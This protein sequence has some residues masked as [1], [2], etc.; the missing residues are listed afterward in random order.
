MKTINGICNE[1]KIKCLF[2][3]QPNI[4]TVDEQSLSEKEKQILKYDFWGKPYKKLTEIVLQDAYSKN[5]KIYDFSKILNSK[6]TEI[7]LDNCHVNP[8]G[9][10]IIAEK[11]YTKFFLD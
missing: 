7:F 9:N 6:N 11:L 5:L 3:W 4:H 10:G 8:E 1:Y 2:I